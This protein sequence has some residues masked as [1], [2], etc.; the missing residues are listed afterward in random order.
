MATSGTATE[1]HR[2][3]EAER[4]E[5]EKDDEHTA[6][7]FGQRWEG[8]KPKRPSLANA[9]GTTDGRRK[10]SVQ[11]HTEPA[12]ETIRRESLVQVPRLST[13]GKLD[14]RMSSPPPPATYQRGVSFDTFANKDATD[15]S[16]TLQYKHKDYKHTRRTRTFLCGADENEY[17]E[18]ALE[19]LIDELV[20]DGDEIVCLRAV[21]KDSK[22]AAEGVDSGR[23][24]QEAMKLLNRVIDKNAHEDKA[25]SLIMELAVGKVEKVIQRMVCNGSLIGVQKL[26]QGLVQIQIY[27][28]AV[29]IVGTRG[30]NLA[31]MQG[32]LPGSVSKY[33][34][35][36]SPIPVIVV[37]SSE[38]RLRKKRK[39]QLDPN[40]S[41]YS[42]IL[43]QAQLAGGTSALDR[44]IRNTVM[45]ALPEATEQEAAAVA[46]AIGMPRNYQ[47]SVIALRRRMARHSSESGPENAGAEGGI[48]PAGIFRAI[49]PDRA[50]LV[51]KSPQ[52]AALAADVWDDDDDVDSE[53]PDTGGKENKMGTSPEQ[54]SAMLGVAKTL[55]HRRPSVRE[56]NPWLDQILRSGEDRERWLSPGPALGHSR[57]RSR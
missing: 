18:F 42:A 46:K 40:R 48:L 11:F 49:V 14:R 31:G 20:D 39:R 51:L 13:V 52:M 5:K 30:R 15:L 19:W 3:S 26:N 50:D 56:T 23:Y 10:S 45:E 1:G 43:H 27:E 21:D 12:E 57:S 6:L 44:N 47:S 33:C 41:V 29:L 32:L 17:S 34:L 53:H 35:Q 2:A 25:I 7:A 54:K 9:A 36:Q 24:K 16:F 8:P 37:R 55:D 38:K 22:V 4:I 28:P